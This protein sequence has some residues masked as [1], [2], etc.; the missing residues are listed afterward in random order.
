MEHRPLEGPAGLEVNGH[1]RLL[2]RNERQGRR[3]RRVLYV[4][5]VDGFQVGR[6]IRQEEFS[7]S[8]SPRRRGHLGAL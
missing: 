8:V 3:A 6:K 4:K 5:G 1:A 7:R 2:S